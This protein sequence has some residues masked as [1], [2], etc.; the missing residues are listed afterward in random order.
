[1]GG[2][3]EQISLDENLG[4]GAGLVVV[5]AGAREQ[6]GGEGNQLLGSGAN[7]HGDSKTPKTKTLQPFDE[8]VCWGRARHS[9]GQRSEIK[10]RRQDPLSRIDDA[11]V[12]G[13]AVRMIAVA[14]R[15]PFSNAF[16]RLSWKRAR[17]LSFQS[18]VL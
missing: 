13:L 5:E 4:D 7:R 8:R 18:F 11:V 2:V 15:R 9:R 10:R 1:V 16:C 12:V 14:W 3:S 6:R 17:T